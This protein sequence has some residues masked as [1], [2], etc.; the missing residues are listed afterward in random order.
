[1]PHTLHDTSST[2]EYPISVGYHLE[3]C[4]AYNFFA[5]V[6]VIFLFIKQVRLC[7]FDVHT[8]YLCSPS[9]KIIA[10]IKCH[11]NV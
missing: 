11:S 4:V 7:F 8:N 1:M 10:F 2:P 5:N 3:L 6:D 9:K